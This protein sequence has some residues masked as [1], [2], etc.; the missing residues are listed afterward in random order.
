MAH[1]VKDAVIGAP[2]D[3]TAA[4]LED[5]RGRAFLSGS[6]LPRLVSWRSAVVVSFGGAVLIAVSMGPMAAEIGS[7]SILVWIGAAMIGAAQSALL[8]ELAS[9]FHERAGGTAQFG[10][11]ARPSG[12]PILGALSSWAYWF[13]WTPGIAVNLILAGT[14]LNAVLLPGVDPLALAAVIGALLYLVNL[15]GVRLSMRVGAVLAVLASV[16]LIVIVLAPIL[17]PGS[18]DLGRIFPLELAPGTEAGALGTAAL[19]AK[20]MFVAAWSAYGAEMAS[21]LCAEVRD[22]GCHMPRTMGIAAGI[23]LVAFGL[24]PIGM[25]GLLGVE[26][27]QSDSLVAF[28]SA[29]EL[30]F[31]DAGETIIGVLLAAALVLGAQAFILGSS[32][33]IYGLAKDGHVPAFFGRVNRRGVPIGSL[34]WDAAIIAT[35]LAVFETNIIDAVAAANV[36][37]LIVFIIMPLAY[38][39]LRKREDGDPTGLRLPGAFRLVAIGLVVFNAVILVVGGAQWGLE[40]MLVG[41]GICALIVPLSLVSRRAHAGGAPDQASGP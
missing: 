30:I 22:C 39:V 9:R 24:V 15:R 35:I 37:Y 33:T 32:R 13:A 8:A 17:A 18:F 23:F 21:T 40:V 4:L 28:A 26:Q 27:L 41:V 34:V 5:E 29:A 3:T 16:P 10:Y 20:W 6:S 2:G 19:I 36:G 7:L 25:I 1:P 38:L 31:G 12:S 14:Y 11:R